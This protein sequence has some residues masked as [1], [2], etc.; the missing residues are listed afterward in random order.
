MEVR[1]KPLHGRILLLCTF[2]VPDPEARSPG[3]YACGL[4]FGVTNTVALV[5]D[6]G[7]ALLYKGGFIK[8][9]NQW[10][11]KRSAELKSIMMKG[12]DP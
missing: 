3:P 5:S 9:A 8:A 4:D 1:L 12:K 2:E 11:N 7:L 6:N 10:Y